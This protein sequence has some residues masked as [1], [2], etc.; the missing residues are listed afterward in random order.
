MAVGTKDERRLGEVEN[1]ESSH[2][3]AEWQN[4]DAQPNLPSPAACEHRP[5]M[6]SEASDGKL[7]KVA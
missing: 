5:E 2:S 6:G 1:L 7:F 3:A 4:C